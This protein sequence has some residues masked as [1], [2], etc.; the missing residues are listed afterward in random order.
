MKLYEYKNIKIDLVLTED[1]IPEDKL[2]E[3]IQSDDIVK[4]AR[5]KTCEHLL[6]ARRK[7]K[8]LKTESR[9]KIARKIMVMRERIRKNNK[10]KLEK[11][12]N[13]S[14][15]WVKD[16]QDIELVLM[17]DIMNK[18]HSSLTNALHSLDTSSR[19]NW[20]DLLNEVVRETLSHNNIVGAIKITKNPDIKLDPGEANNIQLINDADAPLNKIIIENEY[21]RITLD[22]LEQ[23]N[24]LL[25]SFKENYLSIIQ[26]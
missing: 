12:V 23:I 8:K 4:L 11:E 26:E 2:L 10:I 19:I 1:I 3:I 25:N 17:Q 22:P 21:M 5:K 20:D 16:I 9:K 24:I 15:K 13:K 14:I 6:R 18:V 7:S